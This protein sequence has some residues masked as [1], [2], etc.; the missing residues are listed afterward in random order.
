MSPPPPLA[1]R[2]PC[3]QACTA[4]RQPWAAVSGL[5]CRLVLLVVHLARVALGFV[6]CSYPDYTETGRE[7]AGKRITVMRR[8]KKFERSSSC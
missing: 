6:R 8:R 2:S 4:Q 5:G 1:Y 3:L 7:W